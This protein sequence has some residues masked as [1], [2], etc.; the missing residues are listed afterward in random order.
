MYFVICED[1]PEEGLWLQEKLKK[2]AHKKNVAVETARYESAERF[3]FSYEEKQRIDALFL[4]IQLPDEDGMTLA[5]KL[6]ARKNPVPILFVTGMDDYMAEGY[7]VQ[8][9]HYLLKPVSEE[10]LEVCLE[11]IMRASD[12]EEPFVLLQTDAD[13]VRILQKDIFTVEVF[14]HQCVYTT[15][16]RSYTVLESLKEAQEK[17]QSGWFVLAYRGILVNLFHVRSI[18][19]EKV[20]LTDGREVP[21]SRRMYGELNQAFIRFYREGRA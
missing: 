18:S 13:V 5:R 4:D 12:T 2:W 1:N 21:V 6:R 10:K 9:I 17:L 3:W 16:E 19:R 11:R 8:A 7:D 14:A 15:A 20:C